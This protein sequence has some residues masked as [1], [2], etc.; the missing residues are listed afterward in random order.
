[1]KRLWLCLPLFLAFPASAAWLK[2]DKS[3]D[4]FLFQGAEDGEPFSFNVPGTTVRT[5]KDGDRALAEIDGVLVQV[6][7]VPIDVRAKRDAIEAFRISEQR[8]LAKAGS[9]IATSNICAQSSVAHAEWASKLGGRIS[10]YLVV[11]ARKRL[12][13]ITVVASDDR[14]P[15]SSAPQVLAAVCSSLKV[16]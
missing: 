7:L 11:K 6:M 14:L 4:S 1:M 8:Y 3:A 2:L 9:E 16:T 12:L 5:A 10:R 15:E 13:V